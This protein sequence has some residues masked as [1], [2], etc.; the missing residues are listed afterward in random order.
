MQLTNLKQS[1]SQLSSEQQT[2]LHERIRIMRFNR[3]IKKK[4][5]PKQKS[6]VKCQKAIMSDPNQLRELLILLGEEL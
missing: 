5:S 2:K 3:P 6:A 4:K 1:I